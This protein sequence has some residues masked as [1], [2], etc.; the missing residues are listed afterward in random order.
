VPVNLDRD[1]Q[2]RPPNG[3]VQGEGPTGPPRDL[4][5]VFRSKWPPAINVVRHF[6]KAVLNPV[7]L[8]MAGSRNWYASVVH[9][10]GRKSGKPYATPVVAEASG[11]DLYIPLP[12]GTHVDWCANALAAGGCVIEHRGDRYETTDPAI[13]PAEEAAP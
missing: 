3:G 5:A 11:A 4:V 9:H 2:S 8:R 10:V 7:M 1:G 6:N 12:Y 13:I